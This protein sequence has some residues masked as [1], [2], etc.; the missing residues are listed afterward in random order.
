MML[1]DHN[2]LYN[3]PNIVINTIYGQ[4]PALQNLYFKPSVI[5]PI[6]KPFRM[7]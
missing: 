7:N 6:N 3:D 4:D 2:I 1:S 5:V